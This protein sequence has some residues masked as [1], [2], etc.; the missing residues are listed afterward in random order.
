MRAIAVALLVTLAPIPGLAQKPTAYVLRPDRVFD[1][2]AVHE[3]WLVVVEQERIAAAGPA[4]EVAVP[5]GAETID[6]AGTTLLP[7]LI[8]A[9]VHF[10][11]HPYDE[12][13]WND[14][15]LAEPLAYRVARAVAHAERTLRAGFTTVRDLGTEGAGYADQGLARAIRE[16]IVEGPR[17]LTASKAIVASGT[18]GPRGYA[19][20]VPQG[21]EEVS[22]VAEIARAAR[23]H[24]GHGAD[25]VKVYADYRWGPDGATHPTFTLEEL[26][27]AV[28]VAGSADVPVS[29]HA[30][31]PEGIRRAVLA[32]V[33]TIEHGSQGTPE[34]FRLMAER[35]VALCPTLAAGE[36][37]ARYQG[38]DGSEPAPARVTDQ[39]ASFRAAREAGVTICAGSD[40]GVFAHGE[41]ALEI[42]LMVSYGMTPLEALRAA[43]A[44]D[45]RV[46]HLE[47]RGRVAP[48]LL[49]DLVAVEGDPTRDIAALRDVRLVMKGGKVV[50]LSRER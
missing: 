47:D 37:I 40:A 5:S 49:A 18:Y 8:D 23:E 34:V 19:F 4:T 32:G 43:T 13:P 1:G 2:E 15:V 12:T 16:G 17:M 25:W 7:G 50:T 46:L 42:E 26:E 22:G 41:N 29:A 48:G 3:D 6:L 21:A 38:W 35:G 9:H 27:R 14:Q 24:I 11:L 45:A 44:V 33:E 28:E 31:S 10:F 36:A 20:E 30:S 39:R